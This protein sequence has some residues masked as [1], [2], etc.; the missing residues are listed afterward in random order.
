MLAN[1]KT[2]LSKSPRAG[3]HV[4]AIKI[5]KTKSEKL[6]CLKE[7]SRENWGSGREVVIKVIMTRNFLK[8][9]KDIKYSF[10]HTM[11]GCRVSKTKKMY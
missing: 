2:G 10:Q 8:L 11:G 6:K 4:S 7:L 3:K 1:W 5:Y 9:K